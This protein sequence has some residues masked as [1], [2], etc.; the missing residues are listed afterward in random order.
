MIFIEFIYCFQLFL[1]YENN[2]FSFVFVFF[3]FIHFNIN[4]L[5]INIMLFLNAII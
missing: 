3:F 5:A 2:F 1:R 4:I